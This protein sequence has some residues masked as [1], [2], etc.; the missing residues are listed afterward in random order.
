MSNWEFLLNFI[1]QGTVAEPTAPGFKDFVFCPTFFL[2]IFTAFLVI[3]FASTLKDGKGTGVLCFC[4]VLSFFGLFLT[5]CF[6]PTYFSRLAEYK[7]QTVLYEEEQTKLREEAA[8][9][10]ENRKDYDIYLDGNEVEYDTVRF[11]QYKVD[12]SDEEQTIWL[13]RV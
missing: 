6:T 8:Q 13:S 9:M 12:I 3:L 10:A 2:G 5:A 7:E 1:G 4:T 11:S